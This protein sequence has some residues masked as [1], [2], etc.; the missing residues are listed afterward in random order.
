MLRILPEA[1]GQVLRTPPPPPGMIN[2]L[3]LI[4]LL[5]IKIYTVSVLMV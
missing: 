1:Y 4:N 2:L 3:I 5:A